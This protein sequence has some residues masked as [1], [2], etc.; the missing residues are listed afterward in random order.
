MGVTQKYELGVSFHS[1][2]T[3]IQKVRTNTDFFYNALFEKVVFSRKNFKL[4]P[5]LKASIAWKCEFWSSFAL[6]FGF[7]ILRNIN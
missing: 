4:K 7:L 2:F 5:R 3:V 1:N 6:P